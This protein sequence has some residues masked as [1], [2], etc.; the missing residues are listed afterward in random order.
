MESKKNSRTDETNEPSIREHARNTVFKEM[1]L[2]TVA[3]HSL[4]ELQL[5]IDGS[6]VSSLRYEFDAS[7]LESLACRTSDVDAARLLDEFGGYGSDYLWESC[8]NPS[9]LLMAMV[10]THTGMSAKDWHGT[11]KNW[12]LACATNTQKPSTWTTKKSP[13]SQRGLHGASSQRHRTSKPPYNTPPKYMTPT[14]SA[15]DCK[16]CGAK[17]VP[18]SAQVCPF[19][20]VQKAS[21]WE[22]ASGRRKKGTQKKK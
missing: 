2:A 12:P 21:E 9:R 16:E 14:P 5:L 13:T 6:L 7:S 3:L 18:T 22:V 17:K 8:D 11:N 10:E 15:W 1:P 20:Q 4:Y 19:C